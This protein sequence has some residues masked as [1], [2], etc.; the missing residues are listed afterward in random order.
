[1]S[2][3]PAAL[4]SLSV[5]VESL[6]GRLKRITVHQDYCRGT[7]YSERQQNECNKLV[8]LLKE[9][10]TDLRNTSSLIQPNKR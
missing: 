2:N 4:E 10:L 3:K 1:M 6:A 7:L 5:V 8:L 9:L